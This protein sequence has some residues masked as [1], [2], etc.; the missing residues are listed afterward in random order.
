V[1][2]GGRVEK[3]WLKRVRGGPMEAVDG[4]E[5]LEG[6]G[7]AGSAGWGG[8][9]Q[10]TFLEAEAWQRHMTALEATVDPVERRANFLLS[11]CDLAGSRGRVLRLGA[12]C[13][14]RIVGET[15]PCERMDAVHP[16][17]QA[18]MRPDWGGGAF[19][20]VL[21]GG[22]IRVGDVV[23]WE[24]D[25]PGADAGAAAAATTQGGPTTG[26]ASTV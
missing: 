1:S 26:P 25:A 9:R 15:K 19:G 14:V 8:R 4:A 20:E 3:I 11:G 24:P 7:L 16:G 12:T 17:L 18:M 23:A 13:R 5:M 6:R 22:S 21:T 10:V 2:A